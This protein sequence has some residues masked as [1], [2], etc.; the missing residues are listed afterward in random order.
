MEYGLLLDFLTNRTMRYLYILALIIG[1][2]SCHRYEIEPESIKLSKI[3]LNNSETIN[4]QWDESGHLIRYEGSGSYYD[5]IS[6]D[7]DGKVEKIH[8]ISTSS[9]G[10]ISDKEFSVSFANNT[11]KVLEVRSSQ[12]SSTYSYNDYYY[13]VNNIGELLS[14]VS[15]RTEDSVSFEYEA[16]STTISIYQKGSFK[17]KYVAYETTGENIFSQLPIWVYGSVLRKMLPSSNSYY[18]SSEKTYQNIWYLCLSHPVKKVEYYSTSDKNSISN[19]IYFTSEYD[20]NN[21]CRR[22]Y[23]LDEYSFSSLSDWDWQFDITTTVN[24]SSNSIIVKNDTTTDSD[25]NVIINNDGKKG[26][27]VDVQGNSYETVI[28]GTQEW[29]L[30]NLRT[31]KYNNGQS[32]EIETNNSSWSKRSANNDLMCFYNNNTNNHA[33]YNFNVVTN[34][35]VCP[36]G[37]RIPTKSDWEIFN[38]YIDEKDDDFNFNTVLDES[39]SGAGFFNNLGTWKSESWWSSTGNSSTTAYVNRN[40]SLGIYYQISDGYSRSD[41]KP[42]RCIKN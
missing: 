30:T 4:F 11:Y 12:N 1:L 16:G 31:T 23:Y 2:A 35:N 24:S 18:S 15:K 29:M 40:W 38:N 9:I 33:L 27:V 42:I 8:Q 28:I 37:W 22:M 34:G 13:Y 25:P 20:Y 3:L 32:I 41:G 26:T 21:L 5:I 19:T 39:R 36:T 10:G 7:S 17:Q 6:Y 14:F